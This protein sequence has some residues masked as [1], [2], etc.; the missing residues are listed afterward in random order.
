MSSFKVSPLNKH[1]DIDIWP[2]ISDGSVDNINTLLY[3]VGNS[4]IYRERR[5]LHG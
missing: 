4:I 1:R 5:L 2:F 3:S